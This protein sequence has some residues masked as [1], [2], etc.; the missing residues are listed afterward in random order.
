MMTV[1][2]KR[3]LMM[4]MLII[5][6]CSTRTFD[7]NCN[8]TC[9]PE[10]PDGSC[11]HVTRNCSL[12]CKESQGGNCENKNGGTYYP[13][14]WPVAV[15]LI[16]ALISLGIVFWRCRQNIIEHQRSAFRPAPSSS[17]REGNNLSPKSPVSSP[18]PVLAAVNEEKATSDHSSV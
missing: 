10:C 13:N 12:C 16:I 18:D 1:T 2:I 8:S 17:V 3:I 7:K 14:Y 6:Q 9:S 5:S 15:G 4:T 11:D